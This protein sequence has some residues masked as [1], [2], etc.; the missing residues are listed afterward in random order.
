MKRDAY[1]K[2][3]SFEENYWWFKGRRRIV[4]DNIKKTT[5][6]SEGK[7]LLDIG[8]GTGI[9]L[10][11]IKG[12]GLKVGIDDYKDALNYSKKRNLEYLINGS[13]DELP[14]YRDSV[15]CILMLDVL[16][17]LGE[18]KRALSEAYRVCKNGGII[19]VTVPAYQFLWSGEDEISLHK[20]RYV[21]SNLKKIIE[22]SGFKIKKISYFNF[23]LM[24]LMYV[25]I[26]FNK[27][28]NKKAM[29]ES[30]L[31]EIPNF[32]N[33]ILERVLYIESILLRMMNLPFGASLIC[34]AIK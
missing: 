17:H 14:I 13:V 30:D 24:P 21:K 25:V 6:P 10:K 12:F 19:V 23:L 20:R 27:I 31:N 22:S 2:T 29:Q 3:F 28:F 26:L 1:D 33:L 15:E 32:L 8:C 16:E 34:I 5:K 11:K 18:E 9:T 7:V 4:F